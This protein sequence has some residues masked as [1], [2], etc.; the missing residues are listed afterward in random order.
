MVWN[1]PCAYPGAALLVE[2]RDGRDHEEIKAL[3]TLFKSG[4]ALAVL[5][6]ATTPASASLIYLGTTPGS[7]PGG[8]GNPQIVLSLQS[9]VNASSEIGSV[10][11]GPTC[12]GDTQSPCKSPSNGTPSFASAGVTSAANLRIF[13]EAAEPDN[14]L[15]INALTMT[16]YTSNGTLL[17]GGT[18]NLDT[19]TLPAGGNLPVCPGQENSCV[20]I[21]GLNAAEQTQLNNLGSGFSPSWTVGLSANLSNATGGPERFLLGSANTPITPSP[22]PE[23]ISLALLAVGVAATSLSRAYRKS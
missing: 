23:P 20:N 11:P 8:V 19:S 7:V 4:L 5:C 9:P 10:T 3:N 18:F 16:V 13:L 6:A 1:N 2:C 22:V 21:F 14:L 15:T 12:S 17:Q